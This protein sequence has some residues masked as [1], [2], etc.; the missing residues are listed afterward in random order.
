MFIDLVFPKKNEEK[1]ISLAEKLN[2]S[3]LCF[4]YNY[5]PDLI[6]KN[7]LINELQKKTKLKLFVGM[8]ASPAN[9]KKAHSVLSKKVLLEGYCN[10]CRKRR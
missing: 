10:K 1:F 9:I 2:Y 4:I 6:N 5:A 3:C 7:H 8:Q